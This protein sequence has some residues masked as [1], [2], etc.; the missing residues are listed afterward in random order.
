MALEKSS[1]GSWNW[2]K[3]IKLLFIFTSALSIAFIFSGLVNKKEVDIK[4]S[5][6]GFLVNLLM[7]AQYISDYLES[8][9]NVPKNP[10]IVLGT[11][12]AIFPATAGII[13]GYDGGGG[14]WKNAY[15]QSFSAAMMFLY[16]LC[17]R[18]SGAM[19]LIKDGKEAFIDPLI[20]RKNKIRYDKAVLRQRIK[21]H[22][23]YFFNFKHYEGSIESLIVGLKNTL[24]VTDRKKTYSQRLYLFFERLRKI[25]LSPLLFLGAVLTVPMWLVIAARSWD[26]LPGWANQ[27]A[28][29]YLTMISNLIFYCRSGYRAPGIIIRDFFM[30]VLIALYNPNNDRYNQKKYYKQ[31]LANVARGLFGV[32]IFGGVMWICWESGLGMKVEAQDVDL[33][34][35]LNG[36]LSFLEP[37]YPYI[38]QLY[39]GIFINFSA[40]AEFFLKSMPQYNWYNK[41][42]NGFLKLVG[43]TQGPGDNALLPSPV[44]LSLSKE[45][46]LIQ[47]DTNSFSTDIHEEHHKLTYLGLFSL[48]FAGI[49]S[50]DQINGTVQPGVAKVLFY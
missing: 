27:E 34:K 36:I 44:I 14:V 40:I 47:L 29:V 9:Q 50:G 18:G 37:Y 12:I 19:R 13:I 10:L 25:F 39:A 45:N 20:V 38:A 3:I 15:F 35:E 4:G 43:A 41:K 11:V 24:N 17:T 16:M 31:F 42:L 1:S 21:N 33:K 6:I 2:K 46:V 7:S 49:V 26:K 22:P 23:G 30:R 5:I 28:F 32:M 8:I 48:K